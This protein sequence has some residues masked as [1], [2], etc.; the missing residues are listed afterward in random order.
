MPTTL[1]HELGHF[2]GNGHAYVKNN[3]MSYE[4][5]G[6]EVFLD[7]DFCFV[8]PGEIGD[9]VFCD[10]DGDGERDFFEP[11]IPDIEVRLTCAGSVRSATCARQP[12]SSARSWMR[13]EV[14]VIATRAPPF[15]SDFAMAKPIPPTR[16]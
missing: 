14:D 5:D 15:T 1:A 16:K 8:T 10:I 9:L 2:L 6:G 4:R 7:A 11:G 13:A 3:L 12:S